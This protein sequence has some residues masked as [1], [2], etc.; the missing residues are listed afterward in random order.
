VVIDLA[1]LTGAC[2]IA[3]GKGIAAGLFC[4]DAEL[5][6]QLLKSAAATSEKLWAMPLWDDYKKV[7]KSD[8]A[9][10]KNTGGRY[11]GVGSS[12]IFLKEFT[13]YPWAHIDMAGM[14]L[15]DKDEGYHSAGG[16]GFGVRLL[17]CF[18]RNRSQ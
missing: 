10:M 17:V 12:A 1:T 2:V 15:A 7:I 8:F 4:N 18:L 11:G 9:D 13:D 5:E 14:A 3:L 16:T 6:K